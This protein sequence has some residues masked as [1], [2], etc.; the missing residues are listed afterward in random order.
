M[1]VQL[2]QKML[3]RT[4][5][6]VVQGVLACILCT[7]YFDMLVFYVFVFKRHC[8]IFIFLYPIY[9]ECTMYFDMLAIYLIC[10]LFM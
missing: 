5:D 2:A 3:R 8:V 4:E 6:V 7:M 9:F 10:F 1:K